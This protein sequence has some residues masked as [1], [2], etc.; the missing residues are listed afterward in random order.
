MSDE[1]LKRLIGQV[2]ICGFPSP[3]L[4]AQARQLIT[5]YHLGNVILFSRNILSFGQISELTGALQKLAQDTGQADPLI[6]ATDQENG[7]VS[8]LGSDIPGFPGSM[9]LAA[10]G[11]DKWVYEVAKMTGTFLEKAG[12]N[13]DLAPVLDINN[14]PLNPVIGVRSFGDTPAQVASMGLA[15][16]RGLQ[17]SGVFACGKHF[18]G[19][20][21]THV[22]SHRDLPHISHDLERIK[23]VELV[24]F[25]AAIHQD[26]PAIMTAHIVFDQLD[27]LLPATLSHS[28][29]QGLL[30][31]QLGFTGVITTDC[32][33]MQAISRTVGVGA[34]AVRALLAG[35]DMIM[36]SHHLERQK[37]AMDAIYDAVIQGVLP[38]A[39]LEEARGRIT[40]LKVRL[41]VAN[42]YS[43]GEMKQDMVRALNLQAQT[44]ERALTCLH[45]G[46]DQVGESGGKTPFPPPHFV[47]LIYDAGVP[48]MMVQGPQSQTVW[49]E[50]AAF[51]FG[52]VKTQVLTVDEAISDP[53]LTRECDWLIYLSSALTPPQERMG[54]LLRDHPHSAVWLVRTPYL[55]PWFKARGVKRIYALYENTPWM[56]KA[57]MRALLG[58][59]APGRLAVGVEGYAAG[60]KAC[61][62]GE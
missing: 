37:E 45:D 51:V 38:I 59:N 57:A 43:P 61:E 54:D 1:E 22:D 17:D 41:S 8:R 15:M 32:L 31:Q 40:G 60:Y 52:D 36:V 2:M 5:E 34:G 26:I 35:C 39:R 25:E 23:E 19:H 44:S 53:D 11:E 7:L 33:E 28:V 42:P 9:A 48:P 6:I 16:A 30:R 10:T 3:Y 47:T 12:I 14:N 21:D 46:Q 56:M 18:P 24:P 62:T 13:M 49:T 29:V 55:F 27:P 50:L 4:D 58:E 20:G